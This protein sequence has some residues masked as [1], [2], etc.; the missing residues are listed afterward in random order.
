MGTPVESVTVKVSLVANCDAGGG[1]H[2]G[3][4][5]SMIYES[6]RITP[7]LIA[8]RHGVKFVSKNTQV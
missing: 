8:R 3:S 5:L 7:N 6:G 2:P 1:L 4:S